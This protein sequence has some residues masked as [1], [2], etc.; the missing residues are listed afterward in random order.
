MNAR[1]YHGRR[2]VRRAGFTLLEIMLVVGLLALLAAFVIP[3]L[4]GRADKAKINLTQAAVG[5]NGPIANSIRNFQFDTGRWP[6]S[7]LDLI[8]QP[9]DDQIAEKWSGPYIENPEDME[10][11]WSGEFQYAGGEAATHNEGKFDLWSNGPDGIEGT[12]DDI[13]NWKTD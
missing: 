1:R 2:R 4:T 8:E 6:E 10:D 9:S 13:V 11:P 5:A 7:L 12:E 3:N